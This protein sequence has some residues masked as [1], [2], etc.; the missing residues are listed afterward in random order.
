MI[1]PPASPNSDVV[2]PRAFRGEDR[3]SVLPTGE[4]QLP[5]DL[6][7]ELGLVL[8]AAIEL[9]R[10][11]RRVVDPDASVTDAEGDVQRAP[12]GPTA[13]R[14]VASTGTTGCS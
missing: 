3:M 5:V 7:D 9:G 11:V 13:P 10:R 12:A 8:E 2:E 4:P 6:E 14:E 1:S